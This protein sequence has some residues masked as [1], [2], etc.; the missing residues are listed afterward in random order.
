MRKR[1]SGMMG[2][3]LS[4]RIWYWTVISGKLNFRFKPEFRLSISRMHMDMDRRLLAGEEKE[5]VSSFPENGG[6]H[7]GAV[8]AKAA[9]SRAAGAV[10]A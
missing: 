10:C 1:I 3:E 2:E 8:C 9:L 4:N 5:A 6:A 7:G